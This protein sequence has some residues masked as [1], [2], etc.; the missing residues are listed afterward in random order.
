MVQPDLVFRLRVSKG[1]TQVS[2]E[3]DEKVHLLEQWIPLHQSQNGLGGAEEYEMVE[4]E[5]GESC[6][7]AEGGV[8]GN[9]KQVE[10]LEGIRSLGKLIKW[11]ALWCD[12]RRCPWLW[13]GQ[14]DQ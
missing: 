2:S 10:R 4:D 7:F 6:D 11:I 3:S 9:V 12:A 14:N 8:E 13:L 5:L 1:R